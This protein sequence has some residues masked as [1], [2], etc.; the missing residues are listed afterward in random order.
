MPEIQKFSA[1]GVFDPPTYSQGVKVTGAQTVL[2]LA[3]QVAYDKDGGVLHRGDFRGQARE[4]FRAIK[5]L[6]EAG[7]GRMDSIVKINT[8]VT[9]IRYRA[10][11]VP[12]R[13]EYFGKKG[14]ASTLVQVSALAH[15]DW[16]IEVEAIAVV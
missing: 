9:D 11:L 15:P 6:V 7:G 2:F 14:P 12:V 4:A 8:Y 5:A 16:L 10:D 13:E 3:G 1:P